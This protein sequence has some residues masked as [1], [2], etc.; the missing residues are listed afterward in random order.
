M[1]GQAEYRSQAPTTDPLVR[2]SSEGHYI[3]YLLEDANQKDVEDLRSLIQRE[4]GHMGGSV[5]KSRSSPQGFHTIITPQTLV[6]VKN[7]PAISHIS[8]KHH[9][10]NRP[11]KEHLRRGASPPIESA[12]S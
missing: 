9:E 2:H 10:E 7:H 6:Q 1:P 8:S 11:E 5:S 4:G 3:V 12:E